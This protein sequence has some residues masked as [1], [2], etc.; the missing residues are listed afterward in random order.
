MPEEQ[1]NVITDNCN[2]IIEETEIKEAIH[3]EKQQLVKKTG[4]EKK[5]GKS[6]KKKAIKAE[7]ESFLTEA[8]SKNFDENLSDSI[9]EKYVALD[10]L[11]NSIEI[12]NKP[13]K[14]INFEQLAQFSTSGKNVLDPKRL[15]KGVIHSKSQETSNILRPF[16]FNKFPGH[17]HLVIDEINSVNLK[18][19]KTSFIGISVQFADTELFSVEYSAN[20][21][22]KTSFYLSLPV[23]G[24]EN[25]IKIKINLL[26]VKKTKKQKIAQSEVILNREMINKLHNRL[27]ETKKHFKSYSDSFIKKLNILGS[28]TA[29]AKSATIF[30][31][32][33]ST[34]EIPT[35]NSP[36]PYNLYSLS[37]WLVVRKY[38]Y[39]LLFSGFLSVKGDTEDPTGYLWKRRYIKW[40]GYTLYIF[41]E[42]T[43]KMVGSVNIADSVAHIENFSK[44]TVAFE[45]KVF[46][47][48]L[49][50]DS[51][52]KIRGMKTALNILFP[53]ALKKIVKYN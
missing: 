28:G 27:I 3:K 42:K 43:K 51:K 45:T 8:L 12:Y 35:I 40:F 14:G 19:L 9:N 6:G 17:L 44:G 22:I 26:S 7:I 53:S 52:E 23:I 36:A 13:A 46:F 32:Y 30:C 5:S 10:S 15:T 11:S 33:L 37:K 47:L 4:E 16:H 21:D 2:G 34:D 49:H 38:A 39:D 25:L 18:L 24:V 29:P 31:A 41:N 20:K 1:K 48:E 50:G